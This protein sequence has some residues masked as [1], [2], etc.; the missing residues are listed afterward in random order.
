MRTIYP[1]KKYLKHEL[2][3]FWHQIRVLPPVRRGATQF[4]GGKTRRPP[5]AIKSG[6]APKQWLRQTA[7]ERNVFAG[8]KSVY[9]L[10]LVEREQKGRDE[11]LHEVL[12]RGKIARVQVVFYALF[13]FFELG[14]AA[15]VLFETLYICGEPVGSF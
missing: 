5:P 10:E 8:N 13:G 11:V 1:L 4:A 12:H 2:H 7:V 6:G 3:F 15:A 9:A 14:V